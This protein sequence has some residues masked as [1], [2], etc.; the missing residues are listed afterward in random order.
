LLEQIEVDVSFDDIISRPT[1]GQWNRIA[2]LRI[3]SVDIECQGRKGHFPEAEK[4]PVIQIANVVMV[5]GEQKPIVQ[6][7]FTLKGCLPIVG[8]QVI[9]SD[10]EE[11]MLMKWSA[12]IRAVDPDIITGYNVQNFDIP[13]LLNR[14]SALSKLQKGN[15]KSTNILQ[16]FSQWGRIRNSKAKMANST[17]ESAAFGRRTNVETTIEGR[18]IFDMYVYE[19]FLWLITRHIHLTM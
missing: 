8:A 16:A 2:P 1:E 18:V 9:S 7:V 15:S 4:D 5:Y 14:A 11:E 17:F 12:F 3:L 6:N 10:T 13:Y 19:F